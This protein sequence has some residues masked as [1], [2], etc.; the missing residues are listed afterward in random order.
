MQ[1][2]NT[3]MFVYAL[4]NL[5]KL[6]I[7]RI[8][9]YLLVLLIH[10]YLIILVAIWKFLPILIVFVRIWIFSGKFLVYYQG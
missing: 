8:T 1:F 4:L 10:P 6:Q 9:K 7:V 2:E 3:Y 5:N